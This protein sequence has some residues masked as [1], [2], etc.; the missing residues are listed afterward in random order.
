MPC[1]ERVMPAEHAGQFRHRARCSNEIRHGQRRRRREVIGIRHHDCM[2]QA[3]DAGER[4]HEWRNAGQDFLRDDDRA[5]IAVSDIMLQL[6]REQHRV[7]RHDHRI[8]AQNGVKR[9]DE[10]RAVLHVEQDPLA[11]LHA[12]HRLQMPGQ[13]VDGI[14]ELGIAENGIIKHERRLVRIPARI[15]RQVFIHARLWY[16]QM[17]RQALRPV[18]VMRRVH[19]AVAFSCR[20]LENILT[21]IQEPDGL[22]CSVR[23]TALLFQRTR[24][25]AAT[26]PFLFELL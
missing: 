16:G 26:G 23:R 13:G 1:G 21:R 7:D 18:R 25:I 22:C 6:I 9:D 20:C 2:D 24:S 12:A 19:V 14:I 11:A 17:V 8:S 3:G 5:R 4:R 10:L 15:D